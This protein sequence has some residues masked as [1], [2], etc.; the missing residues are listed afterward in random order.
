MTARLLAQLA[1][2]ADAEAR[3]A[4]AR[5]DRYER[6]HFEDLSDALWIRAGF[7]AGDPFDSKGV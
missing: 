5:E 7:M 6:D 1:M 3:A 4:D 2:V